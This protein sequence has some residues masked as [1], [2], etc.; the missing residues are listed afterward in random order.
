MQC[1]YSIPADALETQD[2]WRSALSNCAALGF[3][4]VLL[5]A[6]PHSIFGAQFAAGSGLKEGVKLARDQ[7]LS[8]YVDVPI[9]K[10]PIG[11]PEAVRLG[12]GAAAARLR[13]PRVAPE[14]KYL[15]RVPIDHQDERAK[16][17]SALK[18]CLSALHEEGA[19]GFCLRTEQPTAGLL[20]DLTANGEASATSNG[21]PEYLTW[22]SSFDAIENVR[23][24]DIRGG[25]LPTSSL[26]HFSESTIYNQAMTTIGDIILYPSLLSQRHAFQADDRLALERR[27]LR[28]LWLC[29]TLGSGMMIPMGFEYGAARPIDGKR[30]SRRSWRELSRD[31]PIDI[32]REIVE[33]TQFAMHQPSDGHR[34]PLEMFCMDSPE[35]WGA[36][37]HVDRSESVRVVLAN[38]SVDRN[39]DS[40]ASVISSEIGEYLPLRDILRSEP[41]ITPDGTIM[42]RPGEV[43]VLEG[44]R[45]D[46]IKAVFAEEPASTEQLAARARLVVENVEP[47]VELGRY[48]VK[49]IVGDVVRVEADA[50]GEGHD[51][52]AVALMWR[53]V[54]EP[55]WHERLMTPLGNDRWTA[56]FPLERVGR[57]LYTIEAWRDEF[58]IYRSELIKKRNAGLPILLELQEGQAILE[59]GV[60]RAWG[61]QAD[62]LKEILENVSASEPSKQLAAFLAPETAAAFRSA[63]PR[64]HKITLEHAIPVIS[65]RKIAGF[66]AWYELFPRSQ[67]GDQKRH[68]TFDDVIKRLPA[69]R[70]MGFDVVYFPPIH[71]IGTTNRKGPNNSL[72]ARSD[73]P[74][75]PYAIGSSEGGHDAIHPALGGLEDFQRLLAEADKLGLEIALD[76]AIQASP[77]HPWLKEHPEWFVWRPDGTI[78]YAENPPKKYEDIV[79]VDFYSEGSVPSLWRALRDVVA[80]WIERGVKLFRV[81]NPHT[82]PFPF[83]EWLIS[84]IQR[85][86]PEVVFLSEAFTRPKVMYHLAKVG[87]SQS[88][89][90]FTW[91]N[92]KAEVQSYLEELTKESPKEFFR[93]HFFVNTPDINPEFLQNAPRSAYLIRAALAATLSGLWGLYN[94][95]ELCEGRPDAERKE[96]ADSE[97]YEIRAWDWNSPG[98]IISEVT[99]LNR[100]RRDNPAL[101]SHLGVTFH[102]AWNDNIIYFE[103]ATRTRENVVLAA[104]SLDPYSIQEADIELPLWTFGLSDQASLHIEDLMRGSKF[105][106]AGKRQHIRLDPGELPFSIW[107]LSRGLE[108]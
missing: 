46:P 99:A 103:K 20:P 93:P 30:H 74:G 65:E 92:T 80:V 36:V 90:Y 33:A 66:A 49:R 83:W 50:Y 5:H 41:S 6:S 105:I 16:W 106:W 91:R 15:L 18:T 24:S 56:D 102:N 17:I 22:L 82:K 85:G 97:K 52:I 76:F 67:S 54:D 32:S 88:Y 39:A 8:V 37:Q 2:D 35:I 108:F 19:S 31:H 44:H 70:N 21:R 71:P 55:V 73:D 10:V 7:N 28:E 72:R 98:N 64:E 27:L 75:S 45:S 62:A 14:D 96:Y 81:D 47:S 87:F 29:A 48:A 69:I 61:R 11:S 38:R 57:Y 43:R 4:G 9:D 59:R 95:F 40:P 94:G 13:D 86:H 68:G 3:E 77:D 60:H 63:D 104:V 26:T 12:L 23:N 42:L 100:I 25:F 53:A 107:R 34:G 1:F 101:H 58:A 79:N 84:D 51:P 78:K 89:T